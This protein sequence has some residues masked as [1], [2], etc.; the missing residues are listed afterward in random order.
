MF[1]DSKVQADEALDNLCEMEFPFRDSGLQF[2]KSKFL[3][4]KGWLMSPKGGKYAKI[5]CDGCSFHAVMRKH[6]RRGTTFW[7][8]V[9]TESSLLH[10]AKLVVD[11]TSFNC[12]CESKGKVSTVCVLWYAFCF[13]E[14]NKLYRRTSCKVLSIWP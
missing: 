11:G 9:K 14:L 5:Y 8:V 6:Q 12:S 10:I 2:I 3:D 1:L 4:G 7:K 13:F